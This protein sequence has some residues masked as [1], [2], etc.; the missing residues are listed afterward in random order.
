MQ[1]L[2]TLDIHIPRAKATC[3]LQLPLKMFQMHIFMS[4]ESGKRCVQNLFK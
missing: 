1:A 3:E 4:Q 2:H